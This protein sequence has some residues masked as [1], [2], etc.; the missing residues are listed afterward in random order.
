MIQENFASAALAYNDALERSRNDLIVLCHQD[1]FFPTEWLSDLAKAM[2]YL[3]IHDPLW[4]VLG[5]S[6]ITSN[7]R[8]WRYIYSSGLGTSGAPLANPEP[9]QTLDEMV[10]VVR[11][12]SGLRFD[13]DL[14][15]FHLYG[16]D[17]CLRAAAVGLK[18]YV[19]SAFCVHN[20]QQIFVLPKEFYR[21]CKH[22]RRV[23]RQSLP[24]R[25]TCIRLT[26][27]NI[28][29]YLRRLQELHL[30]YIRRKAL[31]AG[32]S[33]RVESIYEASRRATTVSDNLLTK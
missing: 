8:H 31:G 28:P 23:W 26:K 13:S 12:S 11:K 33:P 6:G 24:I 9:V 4:G 18:S 10:L 27:Y 1:V 14:P 3:E 16:A 5:C 7:R 25:T 15:H 30:R 19:I 20:T 22:I 29:V 2:A 21:C 17:V 32:R